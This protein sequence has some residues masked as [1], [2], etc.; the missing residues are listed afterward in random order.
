MEFPRRSVAANVR[1]LLE[2]LALLSVIC[3]TCLIGYRMYRDSALPFAAAPRPL[4]GPA[5]GASAKAAP[6]PRE[7]FSIEG[8]TVKGN[9]AAKIAVVEFADF[10]CPY[11]SRFARETLPGLEERYLETGRVQF[12]FMHFPLVGIHP[13]A[14]RAAAGSMCAGHQGRFWEMH[15]RLF[16]QPTR[17]NLLALDGHASALG[18]NRRQFDACLDAAATAKRIE[19]DTATAKVLGV[20]GTPTFFVG[21]V[22]GKDRVRA[23]G[24]VTGGQSLGGFERILTTLLNE[25]GR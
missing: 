20:R 16:A 5:E 12:V 2:I 15:D 14:Q 11:C 23:V 17:D 10:Q 4:R 13:L 18:L 8:G 7:P 9:P 25:A 21:E 6:L 24:R 3:L 1:A 19:R 22:V